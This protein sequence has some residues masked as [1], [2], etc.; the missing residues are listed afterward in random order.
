MRA[1]RKK[2]AWYEMLRRAEVNT[3]KILQCTHKQQH[4]LTSWATNSYSAWAQPFNGTGVSSKYF[5]GRAGFIF[6]APLNASITVLCTANGGIWRI[7]GP[8]TVPMA[9]F[10]K[11]HYEL[12][13]KYTTTNKCYS[14]RFNFLKPTGYVMHQQF[15]IQQLYVLPTLYLCVLYLSENKRRLV[16]LTA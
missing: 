12:E 7:L 14:R 4:I 2:I 9:A 1:H 11:V 10:V 6:I 13:Y 15:N 16:P 3:A 8:Y 5:K